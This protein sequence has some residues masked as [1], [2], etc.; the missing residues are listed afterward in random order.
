MRYQNGKG[1]KE[2]EEDA[3]KGNYKRR[4]I[5]REKRSKNERK[6]L[7]RGRKDKDGR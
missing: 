3:E 7:D 1:K 4:K 5:V 6:I 2:E